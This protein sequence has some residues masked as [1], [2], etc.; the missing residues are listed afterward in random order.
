MELAGRTFLVTGAN[1]GMGR[2]TALNL[3]QRG[4]HVVLACRS[5]ERARPVLDAIATSGGSAS[6]LALDLGSLAATRDAAHRY[7]DS[8]APLD[9]L[10]NNA[11]LAGHGGLTEDG[12]ERTF[13]VNHLGP[14]LFTRLLLP[15]L[16]QGRAPRIVNVSSKSHFVAKKLDLDRV[17]TPMSNP[18]GKAEYEH[19]KLCNVLFTTALADGRAPGVRSYAV[20][21]GRVATDIWRQIPWPFREIAK[22]FML[23]EEEG[24][25]TQIHC[26]TSPDV[27]DHD[28]RYYHR[29][30]PVPASALAQD[31]AVA[32]RLWETSEA[33]VVDHLD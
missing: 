30:R 28:G 5:E 33:W 24:A 11:G 18:I 29:S 3:A 9:V 14:Y 22:A 17:R 4:G 1:T 15:R 31:P 13:G 23:S 12:F 19:S 2:V 20:S 8:G 21:P 25:A 10:V 26:A 6:F 27:G 7:L 16:S 32:R